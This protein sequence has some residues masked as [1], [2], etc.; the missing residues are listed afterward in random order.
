MKHL[1]D[2]SSKLHTAL[3]LASGKME[4]K[5]SAGVYTLS[6]LCDI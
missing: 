3:T 4:L 6:L 5:K 1:I 2:I